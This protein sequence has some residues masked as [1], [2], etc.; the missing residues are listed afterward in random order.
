M[1]FLL[2]PVLAEE[3][4]NVCREFRRSQDVSQEGSRRNAWPLRALTNGRAD[5][6]DGRTNGNV[7]MLGGSGRE[8]AMADNCRL[9]GARRGP[10]RTVLACDR[11][12]FGLLL[13]ADGAVGMTHTNIDGPEVV[14]FEKRRHRRPGRRRRT[15][16]RDMLADA[17]HSQRGNGRHVAPPLHDTHSRDLSKA[18]QLGP[19]LGASEADHVTECRI[20]SPWS[21]SRGR[22]ARAGPDN[23][24]RC[25]GVIQWVMDRNERSFA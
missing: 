25:R 1:Y 5:G 19:S 18:V 24:S 12:G 4:Q 16:L 7:K 22:A 9:G 10:L 8:K 13:V 23:P 11:P 2:T 21:C 6:R 15:A 20:G 14:S 3:H 17:A